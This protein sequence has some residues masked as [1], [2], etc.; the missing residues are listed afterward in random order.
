VPSYEVGVP[1][2]KGPRGDDQ[3][4]LAELVSGQQPGQGGQDRAVCPGQ[5]R[6]LDLPLEHGNLVPQDEDLDVLGAVGTSE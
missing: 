5:P 3:A 4:Q 1:A 6:G 2:Q